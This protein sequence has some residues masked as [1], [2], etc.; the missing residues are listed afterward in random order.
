MT[1]F[2]LFTK[3][4]IIYRNIDMNLILIEQVKGK[5]SPTRRLIH[6]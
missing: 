1:K 4:N 3:E 6:L 5:K 2:K